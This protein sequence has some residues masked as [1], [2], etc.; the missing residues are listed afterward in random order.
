MTAKQKKPPDKENGR[1][2]SKMDTE[3]RNHCASTT[4]KGENGENENEGANDFQGNSS[5]HNDN[6]KKRDSLASGISSLDYGDHVK[7]SENYTAVAYGFQA[8]A[9]Y[10]HKG[11]GDI[12]GGNYN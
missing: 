6:F 7:L 4:S 3:L 2:N 8:K 12:M 5:F 9:T 1:K 11:H 10:E